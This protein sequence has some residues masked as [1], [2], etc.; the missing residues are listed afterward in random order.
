MKQI[1]TLAYT[2]GYKDA[3][4]M[5]AA[6]RA[7]AEE[8]Y[9]RG[10]RFTI[11][12]GKGNNAGDGLV[13]ARYLVQKG[14][15]VEVI[16]LFTEGS[17]LF[18]KQLVAY[19]ALGA[20]CRHINS[21]EEVRFKD[22]IIVAL[23][24]T[25]FVGELAGLPLKVVQKINEIK[26]FVIAVDIPA[27]LNGETGEVLSDALKADIT[28][29]LGLPKT[30][31]FQ[32]YEYTGDIK[33]VSFGLPDFCIEKAVA[34]YELF[35]GS[36]LFPERKRTWHK[37]ERGYVLALAGSEG[38]M[39]AAALSTEAALRSGAG[40]IK[41]LIHKK[42]ASLL[43]YLKPEVLAA[44]LEDSMQQE[45]LR[46][47]ALLVGPG[48][49]RQSNQDLLSLLNLGEKPLVL[50]AD[51]LWWLSLKTFKPPK[52]AI[53]T[54]H[55]GEMARIGQDPQ[56][57]ANENDIIIVLKG[58]PTIIYAKDKIPLIML[59]APSV[60]AT[61]GSGDVLTGII[62]SFLA[63]KLAPYQA[64]I[65]AVAIHSLAGQ[66]AFEEKGFGALASDFIEAIPAAIKKLNR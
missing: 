53:L 63:Q 48:M 5:E 54:P 10:S 6:G 61:A 41:L 51:A 27:G 12:C 18:E 45:W 9:T 64:A 17:P 44:F 59:G 14:L 29:T 25:G 15:E 60:M 3:D 57:F 28:V 58:A 56:T 52:G 11:V 65:T 21:A 35:E 4:F 24:G 26:A 38:M 42:D 1:E 16:L 50:D 8:A 19:Q 36:V 39:G 43:L 55:R 13:A 30:G 2:A 46:A 32:G 40:I 49:G 66:I 33:V 7:V 22:V 31:L 23:F 37:Y 34:S 20:S 62:A 47:S